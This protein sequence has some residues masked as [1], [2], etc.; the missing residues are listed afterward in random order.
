MRSVGNMEWISG[1]IKG[2]ILPE[3][4]IDSSKE[5]D[6]LQIK[7]VYTCVCVCIYIYIYLHM[8]W[9]NALFSDF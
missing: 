9:E 8:Q 6:V 4:L 3:Q 2:R 5:S 7:K 1:S